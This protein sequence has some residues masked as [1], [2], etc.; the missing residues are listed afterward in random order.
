MI[1]MCF[2]VMMQY[3][4]TQKLYTYNAIKADEDDLCDEQSVGWY[5]GVYTYIYCLIHNDYGYEQIFC[6]G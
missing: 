5:L 6:N 1:M 2:A 4:Y 3:N